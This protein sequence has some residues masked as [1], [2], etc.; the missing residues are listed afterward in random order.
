MASTAFQSRALGHAVV[1]ALKKTVPPIVVK[2]V[3]DEIAI[4]VLADRAA[5]KGLSW[6]VE[7]HLADFPLPSELIE[8]G[9]GALGTDANSA[10]AL[11]DEE[12]AH[13]ESFPGKLTSG[14]TKPKPA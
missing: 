4:R 11:H 12:L 6:I 7:R 14:S 1:E 13:P 9:A 10:I 8:D 2:L 3:L 5:P